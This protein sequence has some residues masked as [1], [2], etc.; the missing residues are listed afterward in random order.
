M[1]N[2]L[3]RNLDERK[4]LSPKKRRWQPIIYKVA[5]TILLPVCLGLATYFGVEPVSYT[6]LASGVEGMLAPSDTAIQP[7][8]TN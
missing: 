3:Q 6:H 7:F 2:H 4:I 1:W 8:A 5:A